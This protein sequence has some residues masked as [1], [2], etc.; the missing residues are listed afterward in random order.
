MN[1][2]PAESKLLTILRKQREPIDSVKLGD[3]YYSKS[4]KPF[5]AQRQIIGSM[6]GLIRKVEFNREPFRIEQSERR[7]PYPVEFVIRNKG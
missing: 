6:R 3:L 5:H 1:Y 2:S 7:G 4:K